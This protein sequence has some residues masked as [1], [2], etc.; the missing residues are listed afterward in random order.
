MTNKR[1]YGKIASEILHTVEKVSGKK[2]NHSQ[3]MALI[4]AVALYLDIEYKDGKI[5]GI[6]EVIQD[7]FPPKKVVTGPQ[8]QDE[9]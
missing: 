4:G 1:D 8:V 9:L 2:L 6:R 7:C 3:Q 5:A